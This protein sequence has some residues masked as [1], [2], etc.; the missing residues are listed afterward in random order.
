MGKIGIGQIA[1]LIG[2]I[3]ALLAGL[4]SSM[5]DVPTAGIIGLVLVVLGLITGFL[6]V[7]DKETMPFLVAA[8][9]LMLT[10][11]VGWNYINFLGIGTILD[12]IMSYIGLFVAPAALIVA[13]KAVYSL[14]KD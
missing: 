11:N 14:A 4:A 6:N 1:F 5:I 8:V 12:S 7:K 9:A 2:V 10:G 13:L 3:I